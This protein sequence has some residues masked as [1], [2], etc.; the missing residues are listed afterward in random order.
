M[1][2]DAFLAELQA[3]NSRKK[4]THKLGKP[5]TDKAIA[6]WQKRNAR[7]PLPANFVELL[8][9]HNGLAV[10]PD[11]FSTGVLRLRPLRELMHVSKVRY[12][13]EFGDEDDDEQFGATWLGIGN[14]DN[15]DWAVA[16]DTATGECR[17]CSGGEDETFDSL[18][19]FFDWVHQTILLDRRQ[20]LQEEAESKRQ[21]KL[22]PKKRAP[23]AA[24]LQEV[25]AFVGHLSRL[26][27][28]ALSPAGDRLATVSMDQV[29]T[30]SG[31]TGPERT[32]RLWDVGTGLEVPV[33]FEI[34]DYDRFYP[35]T[36]G[37]MESA[38]WSPDGA[39]L[40]VGTIGTDVLLFDA[41]TGKV[42]HCFHDVS[43]C[44]SVSFSPDGRLVLLAGGSHCIG[45][46]VLRLFD[47]HTYTPVW[48]I[49]AH[50]PHTTGARFWPDGQRIYSC[51]WDKTLKVWETESGK[52]IEEWPRQK[53]PLTAFAISADQT[54]LVTG[55]F[56]DR[57]V[58]VWDIASK[59]PLLQLPGHRAPIGGIAIA[60]D[61]RRV[62]AIDS[63]SVVRLWD[64]ST[65]VEAGRFS[66]HTPDPYAT[67]AGQGTG[68]EF[69]PDG[70]FLFSASY[71]KTVRMLAMPD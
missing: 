45:D 10:F 54:K 4:N 51:G 60:P 39:K 3:D 30:A 41:V 17:I 38:A 29:N 34:P 8:K 57:S 52:L 24:L 27:N 71:D 12:G 9:R 64:L 58:T 26:S 59:Q 1:T 16:L 47:A 6:A 31:I 68:L 55:S 11:R 20:R 19:H 18:E 7:F 44:G 22:S 36:N 49:Q 42:L 5:A 46:G 43:F 70:K 28:L 66:G 32:L 53:Y 69:S 65:G 2:V 14:D 62:A 50:R 40:L 35:G 13:E 23:A 25:R 15:G 61:G 33:P 37:T 63:V 67:A 48:Q 56:S 21:A